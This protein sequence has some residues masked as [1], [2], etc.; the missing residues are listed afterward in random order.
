MNNLLNLIGDLG[1]VF[2]RFGLGQLN[3]FESNLILFQVVNSK[4]FVLMWFEFVVM[5]DRRSISTITKK[6]SCGKVESF[7][8]PVVVENKPG[9]EEL[10]QD[11]VGNENI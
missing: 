6:N 11:V 2:S 4:L 5:Q 10:G 9:L 8:T 1:V 3:G 7:H